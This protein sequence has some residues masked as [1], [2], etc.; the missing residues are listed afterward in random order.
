M[1]DRASVSGTGGGVHQFMSNSWMTITTPPC[2]NAK[3][4]VCKVDILT[5][6][7]SGHDARR[8]KW[9][10]CIHLVDGSPSTRSS[11]K[12][13]IDGMGAS[14]M[15]QSNRCQILLLIL[16]PGPIF[17][18][19]IQQA[20]CLQLGWR[21]WIIR[22]SFHRWLAALPVMAPDSLRCDQGAVK[23]LLAHQA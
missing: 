11:L 15:W 2:T 10:A 6:L 12:F 4:P 19:S 7:E 3:G 20:L 23:A 22:A 8:L 16:C 21:R 1:A 17:G 18:M 14:Q 13:H 9:Y 5:L